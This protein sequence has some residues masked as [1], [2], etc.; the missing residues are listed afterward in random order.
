MATSS[1]FTEVKAK[2]KKSVRRLVRALEQS[3]ASKSEAVQMSRPVHKLTKEQIEK[4]FGG[5]DGR[6]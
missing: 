3:K 6:L 2:D 1:L 4:I 5:N